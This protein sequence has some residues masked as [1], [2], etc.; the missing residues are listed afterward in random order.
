MSMRLFGGE[1][2]RSR[3]R[4]S[5]AFV[6]ACAAAIAMS[7]ASSPAS[8]STLPSGFSD[9]VVFS[10]LA[11]PTN[12]RFASDGR[13]F[14][15]QKTGVVKEFDNLSD[16]TATT[17]IDLSA[18]V[19]DYWDRGLLG[20]AL[21]PNFP[22]SPYIYLLEAYDA[23]PG[24]TAPRWGDACP[25]PPGANTD[26]CTISGR[27]LKVTLSG[28]TATNVQVLI[29]DQWCQQYP[30]HSIGDLNFGADG[31]LYVS[32]GDGASFTFVDYGQ[33]GGSAG[34][35]TPK[36]VCGDPPGGVGG[37]MS[38]PTA[39][40]GSLR[41]Q[42]LRRP[43]GQPV[44]LN[45]AVLR[46]DPATGN[47]L[48]DNPNAGSSDP[49]ARRIVAYGLRNPFRFAIRPLSNDLWIGDVGWDT[50]EEINRQPSPTSSALNFGWP[51][52]EGNGPQPGYQSAGLNLCTSLYS[53]GTATAPYLTY[54]HSA[55]V[56]LNDGC[57]TG[58]SSIT[59]LAFYT[60][61][62]N[63]PSSYVNGLFFAD[64]TRNC[65]WFMPVGSNGLPDATQVRPFEANASGPVDLEIGPN[66]DLFYA[67]LN[68][69]TIHEIKYAGGSNRPPVAAATAAP[70]SGNAPLTVNFDGSG[71]SDPDAGDTISYSW[72]LNGDGTFGDATGVNPSYPY[73]AAGTYN[74]VLKV[75][76]NHGASTTSSP[77]TITVLSGGSSTF[78][79]TT[80]GTLTDSASAGLKEVS[81][82]TAPQAVS[83]FK[84]TGYVSGL[85]AGSGSQ[86][87][88]AVI[89]ADS[90][91]NPGALLGASNAVTIPAGQAWGWVDFTFSSPVSV[92]AGTVWIGYI[93]AATNNLTQLRYSTVTA[94]MRYNS[95]PG[96]YEA[97]PS[98]PFGSAVVRDKHY[99]L[100]ATYSTSGGGNSAPTAQATASPTSGAAPLTVNFDG[101]ASSD[102][103]AGD[104]IS[105]SWDLNGDGTFGDAT[106]ATPSYTFPTAGT[107]SAVLKV[108][109]NHGASTLSAPIAITVTGTG[110]T[111]TFGTT[112]PG[113]STDAASNGLKEVSKFTAPQAGNV[114][115]VTGYI[116]GLG[117][118]SGSQPVRAVIYANA[119]G[120]PGA[121]LGVSNA[122]TTR[123][124]QGWGWV[125]FTFSTPV[126]VNAGTVWIGYIAGSPTNLTQL[127]YDTLT[128]DLRWNQNAGGYAA[129]PSNPFGGATTSN[130]HYS[131]YAT[132]SP[133]ANQAPVPT[134]STP[135]STL[136][137]KVGDTISFSGGATDPEDG[138]VPNS[139]LSWLV[140]LNHCDSTGQ[141]C[142]VH[143]LQTFSGVSSG[144][145]TA[146]DHSYPSTLEIR[147]TATD[148]QG[149]GSTTSIVLQ[150]QTTNLTFT[151]VP[152]GLQLVFD[153]TTQATPYTVTAILG[154]THTIS[155]PATQ[156]LGGTTYTFSSWSDGGAA[157]HDMTAA[158]A[159]TTFTATYTTSGANS[160]PTVVATA[161]PK[162]GIA[163]LTVNFNGSGSSDP[164]A[165]D[166]ISYSWDLNGDGTFGDATGVNPSYTYTVAGTYNAVLKVTDSH[167]ASTTS[168]PIA[169]TV[170]AP[171]STFGT[172]TAGASTDAASNG[173]KEVSKY[174]A[175]AAGNVTKLTGYISGL[176]AA[177]GTQPVRAVIYANAGGA[178]G[179]L[180]GVSNQ[181]TVNAG[182]AWGWVDFTFP[183]PVA[184]PSGTIWMGY[185]GGSTGNLTQLRC[186]TL[187]GD[188]RY[189]AN[190]GGYA[191][192]PSN[193]FGGATTSNK[194]YS[195][196]A[197]YG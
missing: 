133:G 72:D 25:T 98:N 130:K 33:G 151:S 117:A 171:G 47:G 63:Y 110:G 175:P 67:D 84:V 65:I 154:S 142:H 32:G 73:T 90:G 162:S 1:G 159:P 21:D 112:T 111:S 182:Q 92:N 53:A 140:I 194:H 14:V 26:G 144:S 97:G 183:S 48:P 58:G 8:A 153:G 145:F 19:H 125:D 155:A 121:L 89:Y 60:G 165:G 41:S 22:S 123:A 11:A 131:L 43:S 7:M 13:V 157:T 107:Y 152:S 176:G 180:L 87:V 104:T 172:T 179:A 118:A 102:P 36:N 134:I 150:P 38:P 189:N 147:L 62:S 137:W 161:S 143:Q 149:L 56:V 167:G 29:K 51:C 122:V 23:L 109:D 69:G 114:S 170:V 195:L 187:T 105:Y 3:S 196:Y 129:G 135:A 2:M 80:P 83:V 93:A 127:S 185:I 132:F 85:G 173:L 35:P 96:G 160:P 46:V 71:S 136:T 45:G 17:V 12:V 178:P 50:W 115:K 37:S 16:P 44:L 197:T 119:S 138:T 39:E 148:S 27:L 61:V 106:V 59:G 88:R 64:Y 18:E 191:A 5:L 52:Y 70:T 49:N 74:A 169:I 193:P 4:L 9:T 103:N 86:P 10:G 77:V 40:G 120:T 164:D 31:A 66:G 94:D 156:T 68:T 113:A 181:V 174:T 158:S 184:I 30:S 91:G 139:G 126:H 34:S 124:G 15:A 28:N 141:S 20:L 190:A 95:N 78:G 75:T 108:T 188:L 57:P 116:S 54:N 166:T 81:K 177:S 163:P 99:S 101:S 100:Y 79:T 146:P 6:V 55:H 168:S 24:G 192:G 42:S 128:G 76:D 186:D 82:F